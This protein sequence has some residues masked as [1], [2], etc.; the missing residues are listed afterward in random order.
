MANR[1]VA[2]A[3]LAAGATDVQLIPDQCFDAVLAGTSP[4]AALWAKTLNE[5]TL[6]CD[7]ELLTLL[8]LKAVLPANKLVTS[9]LRF[10]P[11]CYASDEALHREKYDR[12]LWVI[13]AAK[14]CP[15]HEMSLVTGVRPIGGRSV[16]DFFLPGICRFTGES[17]STSV[18]VRANDVDI[19]GARRIATLLDEAVFLGEHAVNA[20]GLRAFLRYAITLLFDGKSAHFA[21][22]LGVSKSQVHGWQHGDTR[23]SLP[24]LVQIAQAFDCN[25]SDILLGNRCLLRLVPKQNILAPQLAP[26]QRAGASVPRIELL[27]NLERLVACG[28]VATVRE[29]AVRLDVSEK[30][31]RKVA[32][33]VCQGLVERG[34]RFRQLVSR[35]RRHALERAYLAECSALLDRGIYPSRR[36][37]VAGIAAKVRVSYRF[38]D[39]QAAQRKAVETFGVPARI[40]K[41]PPPEN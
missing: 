14:A 40:G 7:L 28:T 35:E 16:P 24:R 4:L 26:K 10:C 19:D 31:L 1:V 20:N 36:R 39:L 3:A 38:R 27:G 32:P 23:P 13:D 21:A 25:I 6:R 30:F 18:A 5:L 41:G 37:V 34:N 12:L 8:P 22:H 33:G 2:P 29:A 17:L 11:K 9:A 15:V